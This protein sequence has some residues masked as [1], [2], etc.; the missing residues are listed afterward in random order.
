MSRN[1]A[2]VISAKTVTEGWL[3]IGREQSDAQ[4]GRADGIGLFDDQLPPRIE[5]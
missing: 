1:A 2:V 3:G 4:I 5:S